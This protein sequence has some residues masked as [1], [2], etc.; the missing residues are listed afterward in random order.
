MDESLLQRIRAHM[1]RI[2]TPSGYST[3][4]NDQCMLSFDS[5]YSPGGLY[6]N[7]TTHQG[8]GEQWLDF[9]HKRSKCDLYVHFVHRKVPKEKNPADITKLGIGVEGGFDPENAFDTVKIHTLVV[10]P[11][12]ATVS[13]PC[14]ELPEMVIQA[15]NAII[16]HEGSAKSSRVTWEEDAYQTSKFAADLPQLH[17]GKK[18]SPD[19]KTWVDE[20]TGEQSE[21]LWLNLSTG[22][23]G[24]GRRQMN[25]AGEWTGSGSALKHFED[26]GRKYPL[27]VKLGTISARGADVYSYAEDEMVL[28]PKLAD[29]LAHWGINMMQ[30]E[31]TGKSMAEMNIDLN[32]QFESSRILENDKA[33]QPITGA[34][35]IGLENLGNSCYMNS[36]LQSLFAV[37][38]V[39]TRYVDPAQRIFE[40]APAELEDDFP[41]QM[42][43]VGS[44]LYSDRYSEDLSVKGGNPNSVAVRP[45]G[46]KRLVGKGHPEFSSDRQQDAAEYFQFLLEYVSRAERQHGAR[47]DGDLKLP[48]LFRFETEIRT[49]CAQSGKVR[50]SLTE[51]TTLDLPVPLECATNKTEFDE[52]RTKR[53]RVELDDAKKDAEPVLAKVPFE[54]CLHKFAAKETITDFLSTATNAKGDAYK[55]VRMH[56]F[57]RYLVL[58]LRKFYIDTDWTAKKMEVDLV[59]VPDELDLEWLRGTGKRPGEEALPETSAAAAKA[60]APEPD[61]TVVAVV[62]SMGFSEN[63]GKRAALAT[64]NRSAEEAVDWVLAHVADADLNDPIGGNPA[65]AAAADPQHI[66]MLEDMGFTAGQAAVALRECGSSVERAVEWLFSHA[67]QLDAFCL[68]AGE[69]PQPP[70]PLPPPAPGA[71]AK[72]NYRLVGFISHLGR[73][74]ACGHYVVHLRKNGQW[75]LFNDR[76]VGVSET[77]P[78]GMGY[79]Y[80]YERV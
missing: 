68:Q 78:R 60:A 29:H 59:D 43:K 47:L 30:M 76:K 46:F 65:Q 36:V 67:D 80:I 61:A 21:N 79:L 3:V 27:A 38:E 5:P 73:N 20:E 57:P 6:V 51:N 53:Q 42:A 62:M 13:L 23:V 9:D 58:Q 66:S 41:T 39:R 1:P 75:V 18:V 4:Y 32:L 25:A 69:N 49:E 52:Y 2:R 26:T 12:K 8:F 63:A 22:H 19:P 71:E 14:T 72:G 24:G 31:K 50:Y 10:F 35:F 15:A 33:L 45:Y 54:A 40:T 28:D 74:T 7:M 37:K 16:T 56:S 70:A 34:G 17:T 48:D 55:T 11:D 44:A 64:G 77:L